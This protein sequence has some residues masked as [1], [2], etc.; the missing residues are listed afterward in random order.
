LT[1]EYE[2]SID[3]FK[4][5]TDAIAA[6]RRPVNS[7]WQIFILCF[8][9]GAYYVLTRFL[10]Q[11]AGDV[12]GQMAW[13]NMWIAIV[14][15]GFT[16]LA[17]SLP[18]SF[19]ARRF[20]WLTARQA[21][22]LGTFVFLIAALVF[23]HWMQH[24][25]NPTSRSIALT[26]KTLLP[27]SIWLTILVYVSIVAGF[28]QS[29]A[30]ERRWQKRPDLHRHQSAEITA[31][32]V[33]FTDTDSSRRY[34]WSAFAKGEETKHLFL[35]FAWENNALMIPKS[36]FSSAEELNAMRHLMKLIPQSASR[37][38]MVQPVAA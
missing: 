24:K 33:T 18:A 31:A 12:D 32:G 10:W 21:I 13:V 38:F 27:H 7:P 11:K 14:A 9:F 17:M 16:W 22:S 25:F 29:T 35:L 37:G 30:L 36:A 20:P 6:A 19:R 3:D 26:W 2:N 8:V 4:E 1:V 15:F 34:Q 5:M 23:Q 28:N